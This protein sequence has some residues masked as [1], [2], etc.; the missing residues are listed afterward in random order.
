[1]QQPR[2]LTGIAW[3]HS[4]AFPPLVATA[5]R[6]GELN[7]GVQ[8]RWEKRSLHE[9]GHM[10]IDELAGR[11]DLIVIDHP[12]SGFCFRRGLIHD[13]RARLP[14]ADYEAM[15]GSYLGPAFAS[16]EF[17][18]KLLALP[19]DAA[20]PAPSYRPGLLE[21]AGHPLPQTW[22]EV[23]SLADAGLG[24][25]PCFA[26]DLFLNFL[27]LLH[28]LGGDTPCTSPRVMAPRESMAEAAELLRAL[29]APMPEDIY[30]WNPIRIAEEMSR[31]DRFA[32]CP[33]AYSYSN[34]CRP[35]FAPH[36]LRY[37]DLVT[38]HGKPLRSIVGG[39]GI[40]LST[41]C[42]EPETALDYA[43]FCASGEVQAGIYTQ[44]GGQP[45]HR[46]A[47]EAPL[48]RELGGGFFQDTRQTHEACRLRPRYDGYVPLQVTAGELLAKYLRGEAGLD[49]TLE[50]L[51]AAYR[52]SLPEEGPTGT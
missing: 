21:Q 26:P 25:M 8:I 11:F 41:A 19:I 36:R 13:L 31:G 34:Y 5:Q 10:P 49:A 17:D 35:G 40:A 48:N 52:G 23:Q 18:D 39:T 7:G 46:Q 15:R 2:Q 43:R 47:W 9:F 27:M 30:T 44:A 14:Q 51:N 6:Y 22:E 38:L 29:A 12:W 3:D 33:F 1:M 16:Y 4:R 28:A 32:Y 20:T 42:K 50:Q 24:V 37:G 45:A